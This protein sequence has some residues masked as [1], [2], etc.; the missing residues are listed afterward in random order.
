MLMAAVIVG[1][2]AFGAIAWLLL[3]TSQVPTRWSDRDAGQRALR[4]AAKQPPRFQA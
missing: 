3:V 4:R 1:C 2:L